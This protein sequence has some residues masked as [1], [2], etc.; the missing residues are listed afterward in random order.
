MN[1]NPLENS[2]S[3]ETQLSA[4]TAP[5]A[6]GSVLWPFIVQEVTRTCE[7]WYLCLVLDDTKYYV[8]VVVVIVLVIR[9]TIN[10]KQL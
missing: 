9:L 3:K 4:L 8:V 7:C 1:Q 10:W 2:S 6:K 5:I